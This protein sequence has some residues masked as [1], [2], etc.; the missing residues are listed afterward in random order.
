MP[1][2]SYRWD[3]MRALGNIPPVSL[4]AAEAV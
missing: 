4:I 1:V 2:S 3:L